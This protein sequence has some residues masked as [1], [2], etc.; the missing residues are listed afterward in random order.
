MAS[1]GWG[2]GPAPTVWYLLHQGGWRA[3]VQRQGTVRHLPS[4]LPPP[5]FGR[6]A[7]DLIYW[8]PI[9]EPT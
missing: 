4:S 8:N 7:A 2:P 5:L 6:A 3:V 9:K 1:K